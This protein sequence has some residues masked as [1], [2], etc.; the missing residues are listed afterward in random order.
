M[1]NL[2]VKDEML[3]QI[4]IWASVL[5]G[6]SSIYNFFGDK[7]DICLHGMSVEISHVSRN[8]ET[9]LGV[10]STVN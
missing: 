3:T 10:F 8:I 4:N 1:V 7:C 2:P 5:L 9:I 6:K